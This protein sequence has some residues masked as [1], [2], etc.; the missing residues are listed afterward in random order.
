MS[1]DDPVRR[2]AQYR[3]DREAAR[4]AAE[5]TQEH[6]SED[7]GTEPPRTAGPR[8]PLENRGQWVDELV[9]QAMARGEFDDLPLA[10]KP[11]PGLGSHHDPDWW[12]KNL[13][14]R[15]QITGVLPPAQLRA[16]DARLRDQLDRQFSEESVREVVE[17]FNARVVDARRQLLGGPPVVTPLR[18]VE[19]EVS[20][21]RERRTAR[22]TTGPTPSRTSADASPG[23]RRTAGDEPTRRWWRRRAR[24]DDDET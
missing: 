2:A 20:L 7:E 11:I 14:E 12:L 6:G 18:D 1:E 3:V 4:E 10:G 22:S 16:D 13:V 17:E 21:W 9:R 8:L 23:A 5:D 15:E 24:R 19:E